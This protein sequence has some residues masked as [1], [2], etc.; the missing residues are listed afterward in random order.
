MQERARLRKA[1]DAAVADRDA[2]GAQLVRRNDE[3]ALLHEKI[4]GQRATLERGNAAYRC[5]PLLAL[6]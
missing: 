2:L 5:A 6:Q 3:L 1:V 4:R